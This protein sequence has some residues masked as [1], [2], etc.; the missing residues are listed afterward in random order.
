MSVSQSAILSRGNASRR[1]A[2]LQ[3]PGSRLALP[4]L[5]N[6]SARRSNLAVRAETQTKED[7]AA[8]KEF[9]EKIGLPTE[10]GIF[11]FKPFAEV[12][13]GRLAMGGFISSIVVEFTTGKGTLQQIGLVTPSLPLFATILALAG[14]A[15]TFA[16]FQT[17]SRAT[18]KQMTATELVR[19][20]QFLGIQNEDK[21]IADARKQ[22]SPADKVLGPNSDEEKEEAAAQVSGQS[23]EQ[24]LYTSQDI[25]TQK[26][27]EN[28]GLA[29]A[30][31]VEVNNGR[32]AM[33]GFLSALLVEAG[34][35][36]GILGQVI[37]YLKFVGLLGPASGF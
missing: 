31:D 32:W 14:G 35:G 29:Y 16:S 5:P 24:K 4:A 17:I 6:R 15:T 23:D 22:G 30:R 10:E 1:V 12:W 28:E 13:V 26:Q 3:Q 21:N 25:I 19:Y 34:T 8:I 9:S 18:N 2:S 37:S 27:F 33:I 7:A 11:G 20:R 36:K